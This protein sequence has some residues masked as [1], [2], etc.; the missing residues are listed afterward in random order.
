[1]GVDA[2]DTT[3][4]GFHGTA[5]RAPSDASWSFATYRQGSL[6]DHQ[7]EGWSV[8]TGKIPVGGPQPGELIED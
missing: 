4:S 2:L 5:M 3:G 1:M 6:S 7:R 8:L